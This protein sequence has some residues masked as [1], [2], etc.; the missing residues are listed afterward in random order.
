M[1]LARLLKALERRAKAQPTG[2]AIDREVQGLAYDSR[3]VEKGDL[4]IALTGLKA[5]GAEFAADAVARG[6]VAVVSDAS[7]DR[8]PPVPWMVVDDARAAMAVL[9][10]EFYGHPSE[11][12]TVVG[13]T[14]TNGKTTT[15][16]LLRSLFDAAGMKCGLLGTVTYSI[17]DAEFDALRTTPEAPDV[18]RMF[19]LMVDRGCRACAIEVSSHALALKRVDETK[20]AAAVFTNLTRDHLDYHKD[21]E[22]Y[23]AAKRRLFE[24][25][26]PGA[27]GVINA[28]DPRGEAMAKAAPRAVTYAMNKPAD[29]TPGPQSLTW[30]GLEFDIRTSRGTVH[31]RSSLIGRPNVSNILAAVTTAVALDLPVA[32]I[33]HGL[34][35]LEGVPGR[36]Q[37]VTDHHDDIVVVVDYAHT[38][39]ALRNLLETARPLASRRLITVFG[40]G[41][42]RDR[43]KRPLMGAVAARLSDIV[44]VTSDNPRSE[45][46]ARIIDD[47]KRGV[48]AAERGADT[49]LTIVDRREAID[50]A[51]KMA[52]AGDF[53]L[54]AGKGHEKTQVIGDQELPFDEVE[55][56]REALQRRRGSRAH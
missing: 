45:D 20:F 42:D 23:F 2:P 22:S 29:V 21:M 3:R 40:C 14:G 54:L 18:Q 7:A 6:A 24:M 52:R 35:H 28:D 31:V 38:D 1:R 11:S 46:P 53:V 13:I 34:E 8:P 39:D 32:A 56:A 4:F 50:R 33:E 43:T 10:A 51:I 30:E 36:F 41:G 47:V 25:L 55:L 49:F 48:P 27:P 44:V 16:F 37:V 15:A 26:P 5:R 17:G 9:A 19:R 12:M